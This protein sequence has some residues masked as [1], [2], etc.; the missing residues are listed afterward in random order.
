MWAWDDLRYILAVSRE[1]TILR[2]AK[3]LR[4]NPTTV[5][6]RLKA[7]EEAAGTSLFEKLKHGAVLTEAGA[8]VVA[9]AEEVEHLTSEL[10]ARIA[11]LDAKVEGSLRVTSLFPIFKHW[12]ADFGAFAAE[13]PGLQ[14]ELISTF[15]VQNLTLREADVA[16]RVAPSAPEHLIGRKLSEVMFAVYGSRSLVEEIGEGAPYDA[17]PWLS[18]D[19]AFSRGT[20][21]WIDKNAP[22]ARVSMRV[23]DMA[24]MLE[25]LKAG[26]GIT[27]LPCIVADTEPSL[28][29]VG[30]YLEGGTWL[31]ILTHPQLRG[32]A[33]IRAFNKLMRE[34]VERDADLLTGQRPGR[35][36]GP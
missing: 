6:R 19:L 20:D 28:C 5:S 2:A 18:W 3:V 14:L 33:R 36:D 13:N 25:C 29:R 23:G 1:G 17:F 11:G 9:V 34:L 26:N 30:D 10:D 24:V 31:W 7:M 21:V 16:L 12:G 22:D 8:Q 35:Q 15:Q 32:A 27:I 4:V